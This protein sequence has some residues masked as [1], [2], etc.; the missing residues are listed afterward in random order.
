M[1]LGITALTTI[2]YIDL[3][4]FK[5]RRII[6]ETMQC[7][8]VPPANILNNRWQNFIIESRCVRF[9]CPAKFEKFLLHKA[10]DANLSNILDKAED[11]VKNC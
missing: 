10:K 2:F 4:H 1:L 9:S 11:K 8:T 5:E 7:H 6:K 3:R